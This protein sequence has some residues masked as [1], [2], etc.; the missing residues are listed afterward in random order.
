MQKSNNYRTFMKKK[1]TKPEYEN[2]SIE[3]IGTLEEKCLF[4]FDS[5]IQRAM[6]SIPKDKRERM[7][8]RVMALQK[9]LEKNQTPHDKSQTKK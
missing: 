4:G 2:D 7:M 9:K 8:K 6:T 3:I 1:T 5:D